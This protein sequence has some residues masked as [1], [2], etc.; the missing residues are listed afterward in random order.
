MFCAHLNHPINSP[1]VRGVIFSLS[2][3]GPTHSYWHLAGGFQ[4]F[5][6]AGRLL[7][8]SF[9]AALVKFISILFTAASVFPQFNAV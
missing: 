7:F 3:V 2:L 8:Q 9:L 1:N 5:E 6:P 4:R